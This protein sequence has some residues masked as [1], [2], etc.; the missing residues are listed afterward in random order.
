MRT[1]LALLPTLLLAL[2]PPAMAGPARAEVT[3]KFATLAPE[4]TT[5][6]KALRRIGDEWQRISGGE[7]KVRIYAGGVVGNETIMV[8]KMRIGQLHGG[9]IT[10]LGLG[11]FDPAPAVIQT[12]L[13]I[14]DNAELDSVMKTMTPVF[15]R[16]LLEHDIVVLNWGDA[17]WVHLFTKQ[18]MTSPKD[19]GKFKIYAF[20]GD[21]D[22]VKMFERAGFVP[23]VM[24][25]TDV[26]P[27]LQ[28]GLVDAFP[29]TRLGALSLQWFAL[30]PNMV[31]LPWAPLVG[32]TVITK[33]AWA[34]IPEKYRADFAAAARQVGEEVRAE[35]R[36]QDEKSVSVMEQYGLKV[37]P[38]S[39]AELAGWEALGEA[40]HQVMRG[41]IVP[42]DVFDQAVGTV[43]DYRASG[44]R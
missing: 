4:G 35:I 44:G 30:A 17:G 6:F 22:A 21:P 24:A 29:S 11:D 25:A 15:E 5:W 34:S 40:T 33:E 1:I 42:E 13:L 2:A 3:I 41:S 38:V 27:A 12:P 7:V 10:S 20:E 37:Q 36:R 14:R 43:R 31:D 8:R 28:S 23:V 16:R 26:L 18:P 39:A 32:A 9:Q 19:S